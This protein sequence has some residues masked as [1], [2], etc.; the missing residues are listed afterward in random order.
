M[1]DDY[2]KLNMQTRILKVKKG[3]RHYLH[4]PTHTHI[5]TYTHTHPHTYTHTPTHIHTHTH[6]HRRPDMSLPNGLPKY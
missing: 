3:D 2:I 5:H 4:T 1:G 6:T